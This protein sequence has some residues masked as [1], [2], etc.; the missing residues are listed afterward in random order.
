MDRRQ[1]LAA[2]AAAPAAARATIGLVGEMDSTPSAT[3]KKLYVWD[4]S[5]PKST[6]AAS[7][8]KY[9]GLKAKGLA[10]VF[11]GGGPVDQEYEAVREAGLELHVWMWTTNRGDDWVRKNHPEWY[12]VS[13]SGKSCFDKPPYVDYYRWISPHIPGAVQYICDRAEEIAR[14]AAVQGVHLDYVRYPDVILPDALWKDYKLDQTDELADYDFDYGDAAVAAFKKATGRDPR[15]IKDPATDQEWLHFRYDA[16]TALVKKVH[17]TVKPHKKVLTAA[18]FPTPSLA[19]KIC[20]QDWDK[21]PLDFATPMV[22]HSFYNK[23]EHWIGDAVR[24][25][26]HAARFPIVAGLYMPAFASPEAFET[27]IKAALHRGAVGVSLFGGIGDAYWEVATK[28]LR[29]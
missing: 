12:Q 7:K 28:L 29:S 6:A 3:G 14:H 4:H 8:K 15:A 2:A 25:N 16:I 17:A 19:R 13:R 9:R 27:G 24:E 23:D 1:F 5:D 21:W 11:L 26:V 20:R 18:V 22:Y 10:G